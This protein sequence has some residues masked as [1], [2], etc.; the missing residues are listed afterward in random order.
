MIHCKRVYEAPEHG[1]GYRVLVDRLWPRGLTHEKA[2]LDEWLKDVAPSNDLRHWFGHEPTKWAEF[3]R[4]YHEELSSPDVQEQLAHLRKIAK[5]KTLTLLYAA[6][7]EE[8]NNALV[9]KEV[10]EKR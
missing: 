4:R 1:D 6:R 2:A 8:H 9:L 7:D 5:S 3:E 10:L